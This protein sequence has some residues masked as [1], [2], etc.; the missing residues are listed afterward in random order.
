MP[1]YTTRATA[2]GSDV[3]RAVKAYPAR[4]MTPKRAIPASTE[5]TIRPDSPPNAG[6]ACGMFR[7]MDI[8]KDTFLVSGDGHQL[9]SSIRSRQH[10]LLEP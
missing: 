6:L 10:L 2:S 9:S 8:I 4:V 7:D 1:L 3:D 5:R